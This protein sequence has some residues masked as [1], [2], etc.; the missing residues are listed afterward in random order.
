MQIIYCTENE[1][2]DQNFPIQLNLELTTIVDKENIKSWEFDLQG[3]YVTVRTK[4]ENFSLCKSYFSTSEIGYYR[5]EGDVLY[6]EFIKFIKSKNKSKFN[7]KSDLYVLA[8]LYDTYINDNKDLVLNY[9]KDLYNISWYINN[10][11]YNE[12]ISPK[13]LLAFLSLDLYFTANE[14]TWSSIK[15]YSLLENKIGKGNISLDNNIQIYAYQPNLLENLNLSV[16]FKINKNVYGTVY[17]EIDYLSVNNIFF[18][19]NTIKIVNAINSD[20]NNLDLN[21]FVIYNKDDEN[22][23]YNIVGNILDY[24][25]KVMIISN[26]NNIIGWKIFQKNNNLPFFIVDINKD[27]DINLFDFDMVIYDIDYIDLSNTMQLKKFDSVYNLSKVLLVNLDNLNQDELNDLLA[28]IKPS[29]FSKSIEMFNKYPNYPEKYL[30]NHIE[31]Y[32]RIPNIIKKY[33]ELEVKFIKEDIY[34]EKK[35]TLLDKKLALILEDLERKKYHDKYKKIQIVSSKEI[36]DNN[37]F[38]VIKN[39][40]NDTAVISYDDEIDTYVDKVIILKI[41]LI[42]SLLL[43]KIKDKDILIIVDDKELENFTF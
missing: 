29:E 6:L 18:D 7:L 16:L 15:D 21:K 9:E 12:V 34:N 33:H 26:S 38:K 23:K 43:K 41:S 32:I 35:L 14:K 17:S 42:N 19:Q 28:D 10:T 24:K 37:L 22:S 25:K 40:F 39:K 11:Y 3:L 2:M 13:S 20:K 30:K 36:I 1:D 31:Y 4:T 5:E 27:I 8:L